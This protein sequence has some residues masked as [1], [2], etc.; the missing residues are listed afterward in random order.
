MKRIH[1][2]H[3]RFYL[4]K[5]GN[6]PGF[7]ISGSVY[8][9]WRGSVTNLPNTPKSLVI[10]LLLAII[11]TDNPH[12]RY[13]SPL[14]HY[15]CPHGRRRS[16]ICSTRDSNTPGSAAPQF[17][18]ILFLLLWAA[19]RSSPG[20]LP[21]LCHQAVVFSAVF[22]GTSHRN[23]RTG[24]LP[25]SE[26]RS[27]ELAQRTSSP[28]RAPRQGVVSNFMRWCHARVHRLQVLRFWLPDAILLLWTEQHPAMPRQLQFDWEDQAA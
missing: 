15:F 5:P 26:L 27:R 24:Q 8:T 25:L 21:I 23:S 3:R 2:E 28:S 7:R 12:C 16:S 17:S 6:L 22:R 18:T 9:K 11:A 4:L 19:P 1:T 20:D 13:R 10:M 14:L